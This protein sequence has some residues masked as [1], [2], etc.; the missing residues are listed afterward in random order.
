[1]KTAADT[2]GGL[3][4]ER[5]ERRGWSQLYLREGGGGVDMDGNHHFAVLSPPSRDLRPAYNK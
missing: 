1:M 5:R 2:R 3:G 4:T